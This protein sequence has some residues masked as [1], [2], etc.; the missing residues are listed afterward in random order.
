[1]HEYC[2]IHRLVLS[3]DISSIKQACTSSTLL[4]QFVDQAHFH[5]Y[6]MNQISLL[7]TPYYRENS[8]DSSIQFDQVAVVRDEESFNQ[9]M[10][11]VIFIIAYVI[12][13]NMIM[14]A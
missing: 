4:Y 11:K 8:V 1:M 10:N 5:S 7:I 6:F 2:V 9:A 12:V 14:I 3:K 13:Y